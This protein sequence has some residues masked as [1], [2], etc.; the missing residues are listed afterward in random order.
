[1]V[2]NETNLSNVLLNIKKKITENCNRK[3]KCFRI[4]L[5]MIELHSKSNNPLI[6]HMYYN[7]RSVQKQQM[8]IWENIYYYFKGLNRWIQRDIGHELNSNYNSRK[9]GKK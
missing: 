4:W 2:Q 5:I 7:K 8:D 1:M 3:F 9:L 6:V